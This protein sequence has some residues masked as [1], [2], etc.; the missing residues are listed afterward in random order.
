MAISQYNRTI[1]SRIAAWCLP[2]FSGFVIGCLFL[3]ILSF[4]AADVLLDDVR[5]RFRIEQEILA[6]RAEKKRE[7]DSAICHY[8]NIV[9][10]GSVPTRI[11]ALGQSRDNNYWPFFFPYVAPISDLIRKGVEEKAVQNTLGAIDISLLAR[12]YDLAGEEE[13][14]A[15]HYRQASQKDPQLNEKALRKLAQETAKSRYSLLDACN[16]GSSSLPCP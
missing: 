12:A 5:N 15:S 10:A 4:L 3:S 6:I 16:R 13:A 1:R 9:E 11:K 2:F 14:A 8:K 7:Y